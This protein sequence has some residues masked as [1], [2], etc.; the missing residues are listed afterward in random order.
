MKWIQHSLRNKLIVFLLAATIV[1]I[2]ASII[3]T[4]F[5][6]KETVAEESVKTNAQLLFQGKTNLIN[7]L[8]TIRKASFSLDS[9]QTIRDMLIY[10]KTTDD[11]ASFLDEKEI[12]RFLQSVAHSVPE[13]HQVY[14]YLQKRGEEYS[15]IA[16]NFRRNRNAKDKAPE[17]NAYPV[18]TVESTHPR[19]DYGFDN[20]PYVSRT[21]VLSLHRVIL[22][23]PSTDI[24]GTLS[25]DFKPDRIFS[26]SEQLYTAPEEDL[27][28]LDRNG[29]VVY[30]PYAEEI[31]TEMKEDWVEKLLAQPAEN[32][33]YIAK[34]EGFAGI[35]IYESVKNSYLDWVLVKR[36]PEEALYKGARQLAAF[37]TTVFIAFLLVVI[38]ATVYISFRVTAP[39][40]RLIRYINRIKTGNL[41]VEIEVKGNDELAILGQRFSA[42]MRTI[43]ELI[44]REYRLELANK[45][46]ELK[47]LQSQINPHF[48]NN[49][50]QSI[51]T[52]ALQRGD[53]QIYSLISALGK[54]MRY[55]MHTKNTIV[56]LSA[57]INHI[58][59]YFKLQKQRFGQQLGCTIDIDD[60]ALSVQVPKMIL[61][62]LAENYFKHG[63]D[64]AEPEP[65][66]SITGKIIEESRGR[67]LYVEVL[68]NGKGIEEVRLERLRKRLHR[69]VTQQ[70]SPDKLHLQHR[71]GEWQRDEAAGE[72]MAYTHETAYPAASSRL[73]RQPGKPADI[74]EDSIGLVNV[75]SRLRLYFE[76]ST[77]MEVDTGPQG[78]FRVQ[79]WIPV[80]ERTGDDEGTD[81]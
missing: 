2:T 15:V 5:Y 40:K 78:G 65:H 42:M 60:E 63:F 80:N 30:S 75:W 18:I 59:A 8:E 77:S 37:H 66:F 70:Q 25:I 4:Y 81:R 73:V 22:D 23:A 41:E 57:E 54:M 1:P 71:E 31:G 46:I 64:P 21:N 24:L 43:N 72:H 34:E 61:Q 76:E 3:L 45:T 14:F 74:E 51:G 26:I 32:G 19:T 47:A 67:M 69:I 49:A 20:F 44:L 56:P 29:G 10:P 28:I 17:L 50:M 13:N 7:Y 11:Y 12:F 27:Y 62:P 35:T 55:S 68:D 79:L 39:I 33:S 36:I 53:K 9:D 48:I 58:E 52:L 38:I 16:E 6:T